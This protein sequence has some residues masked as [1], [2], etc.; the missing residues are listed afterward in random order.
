MST[1][2][3][4]AA[5]ADHLSPYPPAPLP[6]VVRLQKPEDVGRNYAL[7]ERVAEIKAD[8]VAETPYEFYGRD[9]HHHEDIIEHISYEAPLNARFARLLRAAVRPSV[10]DLALGMYFRALVK[11]AIKHQAESDLEKEADVEDDDS[12]V[13]PSWR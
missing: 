2:L 6:R 4:Q 3:L 13:R 7:E 9:R 12:D 10:S 5:F 1:A 11:D 8:I